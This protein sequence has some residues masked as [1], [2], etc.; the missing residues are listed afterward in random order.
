VVA[1]DSKPSIG[2]IGLGV[3]GRSMA[4]NLMA[5]GYPLT[6]Y[7]RTKESASEVLDRGA[8]WRDSAGEVAAGVDVVITIVGYPQARWPLT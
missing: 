5:A 6:V 8:A 3:M 7:T 2:F 4:R 1:M